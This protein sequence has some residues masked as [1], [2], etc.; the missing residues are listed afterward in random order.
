MPIRGV[1]DKAA[2]AKGITSGLTAHLTITKTVGALAAALVYRWWRI[3]SRHRSI[4][5]EK[6]H[7]ISMS[8]IRVRVR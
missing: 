4:S 7:R 3:A 5:L 8:F 1:P 6:L 2:V